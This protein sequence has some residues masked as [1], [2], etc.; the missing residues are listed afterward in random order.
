MSK[1]LIDINDLRGERDNLFT[2]NW[3]DIIEYLRDPGDNS[4]DLVGSFKVTFII[5]MVFLGVIL[6]TLIIFLVFC[7]GGC[8]ER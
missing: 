7:C 3:R 6:L 5:W 2:D 8:K 4:G 1:S